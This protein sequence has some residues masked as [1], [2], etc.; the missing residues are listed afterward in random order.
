M[1]KGKVSYPVDRSGKRIT[2]LHCISTDGTSFT[3]LLVVPRKFIDDEVYDIIN[4]KTV[5]IRSQSNGFLTSDLFKEWLMTVFI[6]QLQVRFPK[7]SR[8]E[9]K[10]GIARN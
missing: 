2:L 1:A 7:V 8:R 3:P 5:V 10:F 9:R 6:T 4:D